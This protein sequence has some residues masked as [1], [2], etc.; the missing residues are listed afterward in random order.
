MSLEK[1]K[2]VFE[3]RL[4]FGWGFLCEK[5]SIL[6]V[7]DNHNKY[8]FLRLCG[9]NGKRKPAPFDMP[10]ETISLFFL[11]TENRFLRKDNNMDTTSYL[12]LNQSARFGTAKMAKYRIEQ[13]STDPSPSTCMSLELNYTNKMAHL[14]NIS[15]HPFCTLKNMNELMSLMDALLVKVKWMGQITLSDTAIK[16]GVRVAIYYM[17]THKEENKFSKYQDYGFKVLNKNIPALLKIKKDVLTMNDKDAT[18][19]YSKKL[20]LLLDGLI[21]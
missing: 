17:K 2:R 3:G 1:F 11:I 4:L 6:I 10:E 20:S 8:Q 21:R 12:A 16:N 5:V 15:I 9:N 7:Y 18:I 14:L 13:Q 19:K